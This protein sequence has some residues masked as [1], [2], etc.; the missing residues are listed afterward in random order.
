MING[1]IEAVSIALNAEFGDG[2]KIHMEQIK[3]GLEEPCFFVQTVE[4]TH[5]KTFGVPDSL[6]RYHRL[7]PLCIQYFPATKE[8]Q[9]ECNTVAEQMTWC[10]EYV[11]VYGETKPIMGTNVHYEIVDEVLNFF[12]T[13]D[14]YVL[15]NPELEVMGSMESSTSVKGGE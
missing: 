4:P 8:V 12:V 5:E 13:Y 7:V 3:Q 2:Y 6:G 15:V 9:R 11:T 1:I 10:L 14:F